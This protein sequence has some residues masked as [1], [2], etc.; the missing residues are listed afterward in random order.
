MTQIRVLLVDDQPTVRQ[1]LRLRIE[2]EPDISI[3]GEAGDGMAALDLAAKLRPDAIV[4]DVM[5]PGMDGIETTRKLRDAVP[6]CNV[7]ILS[8]HDEASTRS[9]ALD[10]G[11]VSYVAKHEAER[12]LLDAIRQAA[13]TNKAY[14]DNGI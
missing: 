14:Q 4:M 1:G 2:T 11:A 8:L 12:L 7:V 13:A 6:E 9:R 3:V 5:M 10:A